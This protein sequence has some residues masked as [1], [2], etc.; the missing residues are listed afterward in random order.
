MFHCVIKEPKFC[1]IFPFS[2]RTYFW[3]LHWMPSV[4]E[5]RNALIFVDN[6]HQGVHFLVPQFPHCFITGFQLPHCIIKGK[7]APN[8]P[9]VPLK[10]FS[11]TNTTPFPH[12]V[13]KMVTCNFPSFM[14]FIDRYQGSQFIINCV[15]KGLALWPLISHHV[16][17]GS[18]LSLRH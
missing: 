7:R 1:G 2:D 16:I 14:F 9:S 6:H 13:I 8:F 15:I 3:L 11:H 12:H 17:K 18:H 5:N 4:G 10:S